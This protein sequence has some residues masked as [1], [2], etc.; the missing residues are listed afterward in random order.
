[1]NK[2]RRQD[3]SMSFYPEDVLS[4]LSGL[5]EERDRAQKSNDI[6]RKSSED[7]QN[8]WFDALDKWFPIA[9]NDSFWIGFEKNRKE[10][11]GVLKK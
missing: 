8:D 5:K 2:R 10:E 6:Y 11:K 1:M 4:A 3:M 9:Q 7:V